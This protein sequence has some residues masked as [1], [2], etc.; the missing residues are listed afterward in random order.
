MSE[1]AIVG[2]RRLLQRGAFSEALNLARRHEFGPHFTRS[3]EWLLFTALEMETSKPSK[4]RAAQPHRGM[5]ESYHLGRAPLG[6]AEGL[7]YRSNSLGYH[8][9]TPVE[10]GRVMGCIAWNMFSVG[11]ILHKRFLYTCDAG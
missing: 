4:G 7:V 6:E 1:I 10:V 11:G 8:K 2:H 9:P 5:N 3:L